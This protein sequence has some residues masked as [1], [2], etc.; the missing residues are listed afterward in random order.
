M[1]KLA[2][3]IQT[4]KKNLREVFWSGDRDLAVYV[5]RLSVLFEDL[6][7]ESTAARHM[8]AIERSRLCR[9][10]VMTTGYNERSRAVAS[11]HALRARSAA[12]RS[13]GAIETRFAK[14]SGSSS[15]Q[16]CG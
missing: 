2:P 1:R 16:G 10:S 7:V 14:G 5:A 13:S 8:G 6:R 12:M 15:T 4:H 9:E 3:E 11:S